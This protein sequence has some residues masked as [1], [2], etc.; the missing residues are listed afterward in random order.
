MAPKRVRRLTIQSLTGQGVVAE[1]PKAV[2]CRALTAPPGTVRPSMT[3]PAK[4]RRRNLQVSKE[5]MQSM[6]ESKVKVTPLPETDADLIRIENRIDLGTWERRPVGEEES[7]G[8]SSSESKEER[9]G[10]ERLRQRNLGKRVKRRRM[11]YLEVTME[12]LTQGLSP[13]EEGNLLTQVRGAYELYL[14]KLTAMVEKEKLPFS[15]EHEVDLA[16][17]LCFNKEF[18]EGESA[19]VGEKIMA[20]YVDRNPDYGKYGRKKLPRSW[21]CLKGWRKMCPGRSRLGHALPVWTGIF[22]RMIVRGHRAKAVFGLLS[23]STYSR[24]GQLLKLRKFCLIP[25]S[26]G[27]LGVWSLLLSPSEL[28]DTSKVGTQDDSVLLDSCYTEFMDPLLRVLI[29]GADQNERVFE[30]DYPEYLSV[31]RA[32]ARE[33][34]V[35]AVP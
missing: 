8:S 21:R 4:A 34:G 31:F 3:T 33:L 2:R 6:V 10:R 27:I 23:L 32:S 25:P 26:T 22:W 16:M 5:M 17:A 30:F 29:E 19:H 24:P 11:R 1:K 18:L 20:S 28:A 7:S 9:R 15:N 14:K 13:L 12:D 35:K